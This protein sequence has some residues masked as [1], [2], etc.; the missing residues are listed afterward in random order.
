M[1]YEILEIPSLKSHL[2]RV[3]IFFSFHWH[4]RKHDESRRGRLHSSLCYV[5]RTRQR[6]TRVHIFGLAA[7]R[8][9]G[10]EIN[11]RI[12]KLFA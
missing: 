6:G 3:S 11:D 10:I 5:V 7:F 1:A 9:C 2:W 12:V 8:L 4:R